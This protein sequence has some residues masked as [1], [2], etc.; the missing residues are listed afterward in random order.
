MKKPPRSR[1]LRALPALGLAIALAGCGGPAPTEAQNGPITL[2]WWD[3]YGASDSLRG[4]AVED[5][6]A[7]YTEENP[8]VTFER[9]NIPRGDY[10]RTLLQSATAGEGPDI[11][12]AANWETAAYA[13]AGLI[14][15]LSDRVKD[16][17]EQDQYYE[18]MWDL[19]QFNDKTYAVPHFADTYA[20]WY[21]KKMFAEAGLQPPT[22]WEE[23]GTTASALSKGTRYGPGS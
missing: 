11:A 14:T 9:R 22:T 20:I 1:L 18:T 3:Y 2:T 10:S 13:E 7:R 5:A 8:N 21:N 23:M 17:G 16:W 15:D 19:T 12:I 4:K 6:L